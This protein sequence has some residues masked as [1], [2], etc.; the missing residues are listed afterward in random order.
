MLKRNSLAVAAA[1]SL[2]AFAGAATA[3]YKGG[4]GDDVAKV[5]AHAK[6]M[7]AY[8]Y[9]DYT[10]MSSKELGWIQL[11]AN[12]SAAPACLEGRGDG[13][14]DDRPFCR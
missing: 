4:H 6:T 1:A 11:P 13:L 3:D 8:N 7:A 5:V 2:L 12:R 10:K 9:V 14:L